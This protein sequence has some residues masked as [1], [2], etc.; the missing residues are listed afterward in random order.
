MDQTYFVDLVI[1]PEKK[2]ISVD[3]FHELIWTFYTLHFTDIILYT[4]ST[5]NFCMNRDS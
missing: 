2:H 5:G 3:G 4:L 1:F